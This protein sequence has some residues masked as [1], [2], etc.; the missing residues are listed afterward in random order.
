M[1]LINVS[2]GASTTIFLIV[3]FHKPLDVNMFSPIAKNTKCFYHEQKE[4]HAKNEEIIVMGSHIFIS[5]WL[6]LWES[7][8]LLVLASSAFLL[9]NLRMLFRETF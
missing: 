9:K 5:K 4:F 6:L 2:S 3:V 7:V 8:K 1:Y